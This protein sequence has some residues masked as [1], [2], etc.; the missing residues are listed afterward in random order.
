[1]SGDFIG[2]CDRNM[3]FLET[4][5]TG[6]ETWCYQYDL[7][8][9]LQSMAWRSLSSPPPRKSLLKKFKIKTM[10]ITF[11]DSKGLIQS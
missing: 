4:I 10:L 11:F 5:I 3:Q 2:M 1:M 6:D 7:E 9:K 8:T